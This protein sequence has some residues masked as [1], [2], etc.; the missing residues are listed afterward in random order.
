MKSKNKIMP[1]QFG[2]QDVEILKKEKLFSRF[3]NVS[4]VTF[5]HKLFAGGWSAPVQ[6][7]IFERG[8]A[9][10]VLPYDPIRDK[11]VLIEQVRIGAILNASHPWTFELVGGMVEENQTIES[12][13]KR[14]TLE[15]TGLIPQALIPMQSYLSSC[16]G[17]SERIHLFLA[18]VDSTKTQLIC[19]VEYENEDIKVHVFTRQE[20]MDWLNQGKIENASALI[21]LHWLQ[22]NLDKVKQNWQ[23]Q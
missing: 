11:I 23:T 19:G 7:E 18:Q 3:F 5:K 15:E 2:N 1:Y 21:G 20:V 17:T 4:L 12:V 9:V 13:A 14:E 6:R 16:G 22:Q 8:D 10:V